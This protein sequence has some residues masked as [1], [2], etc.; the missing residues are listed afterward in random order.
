MKTSYADILL[1]SMEKIVTDKLTKL[2]N[3]M[4]RTYIGRITGRSIENGYY[5]HTVIANGTQYR[6]KDVN[7]YAVGK[8]VILHIPS[9]NLTEIY[10]ARE[11]QEKKENISQGGDIEWQKY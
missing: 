3:T 6:V 2:T 4:D 10:I 1:D 8:K 11:Y 7:S 9:G 5:I